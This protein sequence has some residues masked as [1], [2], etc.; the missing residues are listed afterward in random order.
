[1]DTS[2]IEVKIIQLGVFG[3]ERGFFHGKMALK[4]I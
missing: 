2:I 3:D 1:M 4:R